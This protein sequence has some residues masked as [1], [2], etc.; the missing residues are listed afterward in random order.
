MVFRPSSLALRVGVGIIEYRNFRLQYH[1]P[2]L[3][4]MNGLHGNG[5]PP[6]LVGATRLSSASRIL[7]RAAW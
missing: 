2:F 7:R 4:I 1:L 3:A 6:Y 5:R